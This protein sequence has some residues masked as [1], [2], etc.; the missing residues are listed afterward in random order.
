MPTLIRAGWAEHSGEGRYTIT[1]FGRGVL[2]TD[3]K[4]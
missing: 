4:S 3:I 1:Q 2:G